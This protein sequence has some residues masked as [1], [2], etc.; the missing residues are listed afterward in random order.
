MYLSFADS[1]YRNLK[2][3]KSPYDCRMDFF[4]TI[5]RDILASYHLSAGRIRVWGSKVDD[6]T[7]LQ[8]EYIPA[9]MEHF[10]CLVQC[11]PQEGGKR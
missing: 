2:Y 6:F 7:G 9:G 3:K 5:L 10:A 1:V 4:V 8:L 11:F